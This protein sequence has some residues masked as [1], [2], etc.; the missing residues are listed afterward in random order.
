M[1]IMAAGHFKETQTSAIIEVVLNIA[2]SIMLVKKYGLIGVAIGTFISM[3][4]RTCYFVGYLSKNIICRS[5]KIYFG[6]VMVDVLSVACILK[7]TKVFS[8]TELTYI[9]WFGMAIK[10]FLVSL[11]ICIIINMLFYKR[12]LVICKRKIIERFSR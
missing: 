9:G 11:I 7:G 12:Y 8:L 3:F 5:I 1:V 6:H 4:Y 10:V 2:I